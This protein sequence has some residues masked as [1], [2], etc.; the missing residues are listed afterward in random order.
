MTT[1][2]LYIVLPRNRTVSSQ[3]ECC[4]HEPPSTDAARRRLWSVR[5]HRYDLDPRDD[6]RPVRRDH[7]LGGVD[8]DAADVDPPRGRWTAASLEGQ[9]RQLGGGERDDHAPRRGEP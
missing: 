8:P 4:P 6:R 1:I 2:P 7:R 3:K 5:G 9:Y